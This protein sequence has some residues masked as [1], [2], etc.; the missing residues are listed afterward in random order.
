[1]HGNSRSLGVGD[2]VDLP[3]TTHTTAHITQQKPKSIKHRKTTNPN[4]APQTYLATLPGGLGM[5]WVPQTRD[6]HFLTTCF[7]TIGRGDVVFAFLPLRLI[8]L[9]LVGYEMS[10]GLLS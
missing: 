1:M 5:S 3:N 8:R 7:L 4:L 9:V 10:A 2:C 6:S